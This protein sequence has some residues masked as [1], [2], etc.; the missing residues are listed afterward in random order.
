[1]TLLGERLS[2]AGVAPG[3]VADA[4]AAFRR[5][6]KKLHPLTRLALDP[7]REDHALSMARR[8]SSAAS[9]RILLALARGEAIDGIA[10]AHDLPDAGPLTWNDV[11]G[12]LAVIVPSGQE[13]T[14]L[15]A[16][17]EFRDGEATRRVTPAGAWDFDTL[18]Y[19]HGCRVARGTGVD[20]VGAPSSSGRVDWY[21][22][23]VAPAAPAGGSVVTPWEVATAIPSPATYAGMPSS[24]WW[25][26]E[27]SAVSLSGMRADAGDL[28]KLLVQNF[29]LVY[30]NNWLLVPHEQRLGTLCE[31]GGIVV[32]DVFGV[33]TLV[34]AATGAAGGDWGRWDMFSLSPRHAGTAAHPALDQ[35]LFLPPV[36]PGLVEGPVVEEVGFVRDE[37]SNMVWAVESR[38]PD[39]VRGSRDGAQVARAYAAAL[40][41]LEQSLH[42]DRVDGAGADGGGVAEPAEL[43]YVLGTGM[44]GNW[45][46][47]LPVHRPS[48][49][50]AIRLQRASMPQFFPAGAPR[51]RPVTSI[52]RQGMGDPAASVGRYPDVLDDGDA[53]PSPA[54][55]N[56]E[57]VPRSGVVVRGRMQRGRW[58]GG[59]TVQWYGRQVATG[60]GEGSS[61]L[62]FDVVHE[63]E[64]G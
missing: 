21:S 54:F 58:I 11:P 8:R 27:D 10:F 9:D 40:S 56:E 53:A 46:P 25:E 61:G 32:D 62:R 64:S 26:F 47:F 36:L 49:T 51:V 5:A 43:R 59:T 20:L 33:R 39:G 18:E 42:P 50:H 14:V 55:V 12:E 38:V 31:V 30:G 57:E 3:D 16:L 1:L 63:P 23:D 4:V 22:Y 29:A 2:S 60:R 37:M 48:S 45:I 19:V 17:T 44:P 13:D 28:A 24:R 34:T 6:L 41:V 7:A 15:A 52:L 35:H